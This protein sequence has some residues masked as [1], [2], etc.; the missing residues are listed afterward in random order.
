LD[1]YVLVETYWE[2]LQKGPAND[3]PFITSNTMDESGTAYGANVTVADYI[4]TI[5][6]TY[7]SFANQFLEEYPACNTQASM[8]TNLISRDT[9]LVGS[10]DFGNY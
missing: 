2:E 6:S 10:W 1:G 9:Y 5:N 7:R 8:N 3:V 4:D